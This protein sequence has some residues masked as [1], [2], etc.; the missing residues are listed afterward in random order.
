MYLTCRQKQKTWEQIT[1]SSLNEHVFYK[2]E[3]QE[4]NDKC[5]KSTST[6]S[7]NIDIL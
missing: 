5:L 3:E 4:G 6:I 2:F 7:E 1:A